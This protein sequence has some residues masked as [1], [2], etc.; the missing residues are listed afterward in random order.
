MP[1][2]L[3]RDGEDLILLLRVLP[4]A[5]R[6]EI[7]GPHGDRLRVRLTAPPV[8][9]KAN[10]HLLRFLAGRLGLRVADLRLERGETGR[11]KQIRIRRPAQGAGPL[12]EAEADW[13][14]FFQTD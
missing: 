2:W 14:K 7:A 13:T 1:A 10:A 8:D 11:D 6:D 4:R 12:T 9:G 5:S 3:R